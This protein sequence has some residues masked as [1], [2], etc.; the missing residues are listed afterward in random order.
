[1][2]DRFSLVIAVMSQRDP[3]TIKP[4]GGFFEKCSPHFSGRL[5][6]PAA[7]GGADFRSCNP[8][9]DKRDVPLPAQLFDKE[10]IICALWT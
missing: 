1:M 7:P 3:S 6:D 9:H 10:R 2:E 8:V 4:P 5:L